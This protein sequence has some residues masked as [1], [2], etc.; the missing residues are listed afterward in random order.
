MRTL[1]RSVMKIT[2][3]PAM[4]S[5]AISYLSN[6]LSAGSTVYAITTRIAS[7]G[8]S[9]RMRFFTAHPCGTV[10]GAAIKDITKAIAFATGHRFD[11]ATGEII[12]HGCGLDLQLEVVYDLS[13]TLFPDGFE[14]DG[15]HMKDGG[16]AIRKQ[17]L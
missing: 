13:R 2:I 6:T 3:T 16:Y 1:N 5:E 9:R 15:K 10:D 4:K 17:S 12:G 14:S 8:M 7:S 11:F